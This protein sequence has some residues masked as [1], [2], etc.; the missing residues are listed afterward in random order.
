MYFDVIGLIVEFCTVLIAFLHN[1]HLCFQF[2]DFPEAEIRANEEAKA[3][4]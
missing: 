2:E 1:I 4:E 3:D